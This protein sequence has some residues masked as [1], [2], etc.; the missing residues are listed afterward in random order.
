LSGG[1]AEHVARNNIECFVN[2]SDIELAI[3][4][5][6]ASATKMFNLKIFIAKDFRSIKGV[7]SKGIGSM[8]MGYNYRVVR[9]CLTRF[10]PDIIHMHD[11]IPFSPSILK[12][13]SE[14]KVRSLCKIILTHHTFSFL[15]TNDSLFNY[16]TS[17]L[18]EKCIGK[19]DKT[20]IKE[21]CYNNYIGSIVKYLQKNR[22]MYFMSNLIDI[23]VA[24]SY[25][26]KNML[27]KVNN[28]YKVKVVYNP[29]IKN[30]FQLP[31]NKKENKIVYFG[32]ISKEKN[33]L[34]IAE[35]FDSS[36]SGTMQLLIIGN[37]DQSG[38]LRKIVDNAINRK[39]IIF[40]NEF[41]STEKLYE[42][43]IDAKY[44]ILPSVWYENSPVS[45]V[46]AISLGIVPIVSNIGGMKELVDYFKF[47][48][49]FNPYDDKSFVEIINNISRDNFIHPRPDNKVLMKLNLFT[50]KQYQ[51]DIIS[52]YNN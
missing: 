18:C 38:E 29:C 1:G 28:K 27:L 51:K 5:C 41:L 20:I 49:C 30:N 48:Y 34:R 44:L 42:E 8:Y 4:T 24:P 33:I 50:N 32:R 21:N 3:L 52:I 36:C 46:E 19:F 2:D 9:E 15:C 25:F 12:A 17:K 7:F 47:G 22:I 23:H 39:M 14:Y 13:F 40:K 45:I 37:G 10:K 6:D 16:S 26:M 35:L 43:I 11:Y 31:H